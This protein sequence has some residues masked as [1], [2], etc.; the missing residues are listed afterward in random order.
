MAGVKS[1][2]LKRL[3]VSMLLL[4]IYNEFLVYYIVLSQCHWPTIVTEQVNKNKIKV[5]ILADV[6]LLG[7]REGHWFDKLRRLDLMLHI[8][9]SNIPKFFKNLA[10]RK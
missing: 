7:S 9:S 8:R 3:F 10:L 4:M 6:H 1:K 2:K 5:M